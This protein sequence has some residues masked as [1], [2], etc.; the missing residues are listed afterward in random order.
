M[1]LILVINPYKIGY[2]T[3]A[4]IG[5]RLETG[6]SPDKVVSVLLSISGVT[7]VVMGAGQYDFFVHLSLSEHGGIPAVCCRKTQE[8]PR[9]C[10][11]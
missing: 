1:D 6:A 10:Q 4:I 8:H 7:N 2:N 3:F 9:N 5:I 11:H